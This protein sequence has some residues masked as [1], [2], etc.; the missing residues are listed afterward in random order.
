MRLAIVAATVLIASPVLA[1]SS[2]DLEAACSSPTGTKGETICNS[3][4]N[5]FV[6]GLQMDQLLNEAG[7]P[8]CIDQ[9]STIRVRKIVGDFFAAHP[10]FRQVDS[11][12]VVGYALLQAYRCPK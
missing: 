3:F 4:L 11:G 7:T 6:A 1:S 2:G 12:S 5:G 10:E 8:I 9:S